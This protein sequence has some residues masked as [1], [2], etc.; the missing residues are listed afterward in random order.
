MV[1]EFDTQCGTAQGEDSLQLH[2][3]AKRAPRALTW[4]QVRR[5]G[6]GS[7]RREDLGWGGV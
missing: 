6:V 3:P 5:V 7:R 4:S 1:L 2:I